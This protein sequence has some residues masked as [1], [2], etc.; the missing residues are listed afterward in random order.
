MLYIGNKTNFALHIILYV[1]Y[2]LVKKTLVIFFFL[3]ALVVSKMLYFFTMVICTSPYIYFKSTTVLQKKVSTSF[4]PLQNC[5]I[6]LR[7]FSQVWFQ[8]TKL[9]VR[10]SILYDIIKYNIWI[11]INIP[12]SNWIYIWITSERK[13]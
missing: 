1:A 3:C 10:L 8:F 5:I 9:F 7:S 12:P 2:F 6:W 13:K 4:V 11:T